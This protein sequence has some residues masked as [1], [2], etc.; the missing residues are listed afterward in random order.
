[1]WVFTAALQNDPCQPYFGSNST[2]ILEWWGWNILALRAC[3][4]VGKDMRRH[5]FVILV[6]IFAYPAAGLRSQWIV[7]DLGSDSDSSLKL[8]TLTPTLTLLWLW[9]NR[10]YSIFRR[11]IL[12]SYF[13]DFTFD[14][15]LTGDTPIYS[16]FSPTTD[17]G[18]HHNLWFFRMLSACQPLNA[19]AQSQ[20]IVMVLNLAQIP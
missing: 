1:M 7:S 6:A 20:M 19:L 9:L 3:C 10:M 12:C 4:R 11:A 13:L 16:P 14:C 5:I 15:I 18:G 8:L 2:T 17:A